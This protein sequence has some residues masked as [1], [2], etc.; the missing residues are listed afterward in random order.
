MQS[1]SV[2][3]VKAVSVRED[4]FPSVKLNMP[5]I[6][7]RIWREKIAVLPE[8]DAEKEHLYVFGLNTKANLKAIAHVSTGTLNESLAHPREI[9]RPLIA[10]AAHSFILAHNHPSGETTPSQAD[11]RMTQ[12]MNECGKM[13]EIRML[14]HVIVGD[15]YFSFSEGG[16]IC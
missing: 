10:M 11:I 13:F 12:K 4:I 8:Y 1:S 7:E 9:F 14:D 15:S 16:Y 2:S 5:E 6:V 3:F